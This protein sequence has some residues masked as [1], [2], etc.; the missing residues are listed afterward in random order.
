MA[1]RIVKVRNPFLVLFLPFSLAFVS[2]PSAFSWELKDADVIDWLDVYE[3]KDQEIPFSRN[4]VVIL[5]D[6]LTLNNSEIWFNNR[7]RSDLSHEELK[8]NPIPAN[9]GTVTFLAKRLTLGLNNEIYAKGISGD[10][11]AK[12]RKGSDI[13]II[14][15]ELYLDVVVEESEQAPVLFNKSHL[16]VI[17]YGGQGE[18]GNMGLPERST[19]SIVFATL[20]FT[21]PVRKH[22]DSYFVKLVE[23]LKPNGCE[24]SLDDMALVN[25]AFNRKNPNKFDGAKCSDAKKQWGLALDW[26]LENNAPEWLRKYIKWVGSVPI[27]S[28]RE[29]TVGDFY[30]LDITQ[31]DSIHVPDV[32]SSVYSEWATRLA[33]KYVNKLAASLDIGDPISIDQ[34]LRNGLTIPEV[35]IDPKHSKEFM[36]DTD[37]LFDTA[38]AYGI[39]QPNQPEWKKAIRIRE[40]IPRVLS[41]FTNNERK[42]GYGI[43]L[44]HP[45]S[46]DKIL[47]AVPHHLLLKL[48]SL[49][50]KIHAVFRDGSKMQLTCVK[51]AEKHC[52][53]DEDL[54]LA[55][56]ES[57]LPPGW[58]WDDLIYG[59][60]ELG[61]DIALIGKLGDRGVP[62]WISRRTGQVIDSCSKP[63]NCEVIVKNISSFDGA[64]GGAYISE[65]GIV[66]MHI[67]TVPELKSVRGHS[68]DLIKRVATDV[69]KQK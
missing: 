53:I 31:A 22:I 30:R 46:I 19:F 41:A 26:E 48:G 28:R 49:A 57:A 2:T 11:E 51:P 64:S 55:L 4:D 58:K 24:F 69:L 65:D 8:T 10:F 39:M 52:R 16:E 7:T 20:D 38:V 29:V 61:K 62:W 25:S 68:I 5:S 6:E 18:N 17:N 60:A 35:P 12:Y 66:G 56:L 15:Q 45:N 63:P 14:V 32:P 54:D 1:A 67:G 34:T 40:S 3:I 27:I 59:Q 42:S 47:I 36:R 37:H 43:P 23:A 21:E 33:R 9:P 44:A 13:R 50:H